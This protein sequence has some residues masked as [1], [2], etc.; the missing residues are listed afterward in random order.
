MLAGNVPSPPRERGRWLVALVVLL[1]G[2]GAMVAVLSGRVAS[3]SPPP[4]PAAAS[5]PSPAASVLDPLTGTRRYVSD[6]KPS[7]RA[8]VVAPPARQRAPAHAGAATEP[9]QDPVARTWMEGFYPIYEVAQRSFHVNWLLIASIHRQETAF[10][11]AAGTYHGL[12]YAG[13]CGGPMQ[14]NVEN[15]GAGTSSTWETVK[16]SYRDG[17]RPSFYDHRTATHPSIYDDFDAIMAATHLLELDGAGRLLDD[18]AWWAAYDYYGHDTY[19][20]QYADEV[21][22]RAIGW[23][24][25]GFCAGCATSSRLLAA[26]GAAYGAPVLAELEAEA[27]RLT[28]K[29]RRAARRRRGRSLRSCRRA[30]AC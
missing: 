4:L 21:L 15:G 16:D 11:T 18:S 26:V 7:Q 17:P 30:A 13:C 2:I 5:T 19:G 1:A 8:K 9:L 24:Q 10:S 20:V 23:S 25:H 14:F 28:P 3:E 29:R 22:A 6:L 12:N 27:A